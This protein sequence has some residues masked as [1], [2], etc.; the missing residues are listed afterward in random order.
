[1]LLEEKLLNLTLFAE[2]S[3]ESGGGGTATDEAESGD[4]KTDDEQAKESS[5]DDSQKGEGDGDKAKDEGG[6]YTAE[7]FE[8]PEGMEVDEAMM[9]D[10]LEVANNKGLSGKE[11]DQ[12]LVSLYA[13]KMKEATDRT[14]EQ[15]EGI[16]KGWSDEAKSH[17]VYGGDDYKENKAIM[18]GALNHFGNQE[19]VK[20]GEHFG[21]M[22]NPDF[23]LFLYNAGK[24]LTEDQIAQGR[25]NNVVPIESRWYG[26]DG[27]GG[28][29]K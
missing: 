17:K 28:A 13:N 25:E 27:E 26:E 7:S 14:M 4:E 21:W 19:L 16:R 8:M 11:R 9:T 1:M 2:D 6:E 29:D 18:M 10:F 5:D 23:Q 22:D 15:W 12:A 24:T 20:M 3:G